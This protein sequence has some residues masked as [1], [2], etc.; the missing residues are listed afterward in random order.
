MGS[1]V[2]RQSEKLN[3]R[4]QMIDEYAQIEK[5]LGDNI[6]RPPFWGGYE[7]RPYTFEFMQGHQNRLHDRFRFELDEK[8][9]FK[10]ERL[11]P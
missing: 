1:W 5:D 6:S 8:G 10:S 4:A 11:W 3:S 7:I 9:Q 2:S